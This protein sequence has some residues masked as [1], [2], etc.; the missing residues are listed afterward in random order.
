[1]TQ[2]PS[3][4]AGQA[5]GRPVPQTAGQRLIAAFEAD[6]AERELALDPRERVHLEQAAEIAD[7]IEE[8]RRKIKRTG[9]LITNEISGAVR[10]NPLLSHERGLRNDLTKALAAIGLEPPAETRQLTPAEQYRSRTKGSGPRN[11]AHRERM[12]RGEL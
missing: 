7:R 4:T 12:A 6:L 9:L 8:V 5:A 1:M 2:S 10:A 11:R 3:E